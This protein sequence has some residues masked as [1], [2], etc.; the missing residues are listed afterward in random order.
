MYVCSLDLSKNKYNIFGF[1]LLEGFGNLYIQCRNNLV[2]V[3]SIFQHNLL[4]LD[5]VVGWQCCQFRFF[6]RQ[7]WLFL[8][9]KNLRIYLY[10]VSFCSRFVFFTND[11][12]LYI[13]FG[14]HFPICCL[15]FIFRFSNFSFFFS[16]FRLFVQF[17]F[18]VFIQCCSS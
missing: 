4:V 6:P 1:I 11:L 14:D 13:Y 10:S 5:K 9:V 17:L 3:N 15:I 18:D 16:F 8:K 2:L 7:I 12:K